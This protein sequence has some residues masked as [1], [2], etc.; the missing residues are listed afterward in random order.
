MHSTDSSHLTHG[1]HLR[2]LSLVEDYKLHLLTALINE[3]PWY[4]S[5]RNDKKRFYKS[6]NFLV[7][8]HSRFMIQTAQGVK[9]ED[10]KYCQYQ[11]K[12]DNLKALATCADTSSSNA[13]LAQKALRYRNKAN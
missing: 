4:E 1:R 12:L 7:D 11:K 3:M 10:P 2:R 6:T 9:F 8:L 5:K 13:L